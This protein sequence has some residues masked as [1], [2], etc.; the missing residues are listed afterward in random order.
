MGAN[1]VFLLCATASS[2]WL[3]VALFMN[4]PQYL[5]NLLVSTEEIAEEHLA[6]FMEAVLAVKG[7]ASHIFQGSEQVLYIKVDNSQLDKEGLQAIIN[8]HTEEMIKN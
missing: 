6:S 4:P 7:V 2:T 3:I 1:Y 5:A 8:Q